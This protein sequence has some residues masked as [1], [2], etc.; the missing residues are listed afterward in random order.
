MQKRLATAGGFCDAVEARGLR[1]SV[2]WEMLHR[3]LACETEEEM[4]QI[5]GLLMDL[6]PTCKTERALERKMVQI[7]DSEEWKQ[8]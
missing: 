4:Q 6:L 5:L 3:I 8:A 2:M 7:L 1:L